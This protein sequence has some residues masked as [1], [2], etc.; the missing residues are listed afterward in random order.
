MKKTAFFAPLVALGMSLALSAPASS[1][2]IL[3]NTHLNSKGKVI[4]SYSTFGDFWAALSIY[5]VNPTTFATLYADFGSKGLV[6]AV[7]ASNA[8][9][10]QITFDT[11]AFKVS[12]NGLTWSGEG[13]KVDPANTQ[14]NAGSKAVPGPTVGA[15]LAGGLALLGFLAWRRK[16]AAI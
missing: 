8:W 5:V 9:I 14:V 11:A 10:S 2:T 7:G 16:Y 1:T 12:A 15:G 3:D 4:T 13:V 6:T